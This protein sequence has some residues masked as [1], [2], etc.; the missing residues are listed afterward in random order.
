MCSFYDF[1]SLRL[2]G[3]IVVPDHPSCVTGVISVFPR[4]EIYNFY[5][6]IISGPALSLFLNKLSVGKRI[7]FTSSIDPPQE[8]RL[9]YKFVVEIY[10][11]LTFL[12]RITITIYD[13]KNADYFITSY[14]TS[15]GEL[16]YHINSKSSNKHLDHLLI[17]S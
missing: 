9:L 8:Y 12:Y 14:Y 17:S 10:L 15:K 7:N 2:P 4:G 1:Y 16:K 6:Q 5:Q 11:Q 13:T 3:T